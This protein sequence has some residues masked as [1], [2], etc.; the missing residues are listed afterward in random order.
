MTIIGC[1]PELAFEGL[2]D[3]FGGS[4]G[5]GHVFSYDTEHMA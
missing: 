4:G 5:I 1:K 3:S 2:I